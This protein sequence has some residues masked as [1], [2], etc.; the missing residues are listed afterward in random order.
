MKTIRESH[1][2]KLRDLLYAARTHVPGDL[3]SE[4]DA[5]LNIIPSDVEWAR[6]SNSE[7]ARIGECSLQV[8]RLD[9]GSWKWWV[10]V[11]SN[12]IT[13]LSDGLSPTLEQA[14]QTAIEV[15]LEEIS[16]TP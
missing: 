9:D 8:N 2:R 3:R 11:D 15:A 10:G 4:I 1:V 14:R 16:F 6:V 13:F 12:S 5:A 7:V